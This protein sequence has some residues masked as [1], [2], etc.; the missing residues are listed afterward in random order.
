MANGCRNGI[1][2]GTDR[3]QSDVESCCM[4]VK[5]MKTAKKYTWKGGGNFYEEIFMFVVC[6]R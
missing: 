1:Q 3:K 6:K 2:E 4:Q 5:S